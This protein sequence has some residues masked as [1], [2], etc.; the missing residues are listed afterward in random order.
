MKVILI[1][2]V[3]GA[4]SISTTTPAELYIAT[5]DNRQFW[6]FG[7]RTGEARRAN[8]D[9][10]LYRIDGKADI[11]HV[12]VELLGQVWRRSQLTLSVPSSMLPHL[13]HAQRIARAT[14]HTL[15]VCIDCAE[16]ADLVVAFA[17]P[18]DGP[19]NSFCTSRQLMGTVPLEPLS[20]ER[21]TS[22][23]RN[24]VESVHYGLQ[25][26][27]EES[28]VLPPGMTIEAPA[29]TSFMLIQNPNGI[30]IS[31]YFQGR[32]TSPIR[33][34]CIVGFEPEL[35]LTAAAAACV[36]RMIAPFSAFG[37]AAHVGYFGFNSSRQPASEFALRKT[38]QAIEYCVRE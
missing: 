17:C 24:A 29:E 9:Q 13:T 35:N 21:W 5:S 11:A 6:T 20:P 12:P 18:L 27:E 8:I 31:T 25:L 37:A 1:A 38:I 14:G 10:P 26:S 34:Y 16:Q 23:V 22:A 7:P 32:Y 36:T 2:V 33:S 19:S 30:E 28:S 4:C 3:L 15:Q